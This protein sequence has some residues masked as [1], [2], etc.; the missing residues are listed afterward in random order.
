MQTVQQHV[1]LPAHQCWWNLLKVIMPT[2]REG[3]LE[4]VSTTKT[5]S[6]IS[7]YLLTSVF[8]AYQ[9]RFWA[10]TLAA[11]RWTTQNFGTKKFK[12]KR[13]RSSKPVTCL[14]LNL[15]LRTTSGKPCEMAE[16]PKSAQDRNPCAPFR[17]LV[18]ETAQGLLA[19]TS[20]YLHDATCMTTVPKARNVLRTP[21]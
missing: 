6:S 17:L 20:M 15:S 9:K 2:T 16:V 13:Y 8:V 21:L 19:N 4:P 3:S 7:T 18:S 14:Y 1:L 11:S 5:V 10:W 12:D